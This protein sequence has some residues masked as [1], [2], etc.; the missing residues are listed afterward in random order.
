MFGKQNPIQNVGEMSQTLGMSVV[1]VLRHLQSIRKVKKLDERVSNELKEN[2]NVRWFEVYLM[3]YLR[4]VNNPFLDR[5][6]ACK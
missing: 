3:I 5:T 6:V 1:T 2:Q 4:N